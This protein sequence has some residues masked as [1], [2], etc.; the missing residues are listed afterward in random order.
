MTVEVM[1]VPE[2][3]EASKVQRRRRRGPRRHRGRQN[4]VPNVA[5]IEVVKLFSKSTAPEATGIV[6]N[7]AT[8]APD[9][10]FLF[11]IF[12]STPTVLSVKASHLARLHT[13]A[14]AATYLQ[15]QKSSVLLIMRHKSA[16]NLLFPLLCVR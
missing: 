6:S 5:F 14:E 3:P 11:A 16:A 13:L 8:L 4:V 12:Q 15:S 7:R 10:C 9:V 2:V 1:S